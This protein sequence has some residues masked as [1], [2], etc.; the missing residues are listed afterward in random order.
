[1]WI[2]T[3]YS[4][5]G[6]SFYGHIKFKFYILRWPPITFQVD[7][8]GWSQ[9]MKSL[10]ACDLPREETASQAVLRTA[11]LRGSP[12][13]AGRVRHI[14]C[15]TEPC[16]SRPTSPRLLQPVLISLPGMMQGLFFPPCTREALGRA[17]P[18]NGRK[19]LGAEVLS[20]LIRLGNTGS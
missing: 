5:S 6:V 15:C 11:A 1:M 10:V 16:T 4:L 2:S 7:L 3:I 18:R 17:G 19:V 9:P 20:Q 13:A 14:A 12:L 8:R